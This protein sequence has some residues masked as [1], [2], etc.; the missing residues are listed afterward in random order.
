VKSAEHFSR[1]RFILQ[2]RFEEE[3]VLTFY[4]ES[5]PIPGFHVD[6]VKVGQT[7]ALLNAE[8]KRFMDLTEGVRLEEMETCWAFKGTLVD[9]MH[10]ATTILLAAADAK[11]HGNS[12]SCFYCSKV[13]KN[14]CGKCKMAHFCS[15]EC[16]AQAWP[17]HKHL[18]TDSSKLL[19]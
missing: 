17:K 14:C 3:L 12:V 1:H 10:E 4:P 13:A 6:Q 5:P 15:R 19:H 16:Q 11:T 9:V 18:C 8:K 2:T 7:F